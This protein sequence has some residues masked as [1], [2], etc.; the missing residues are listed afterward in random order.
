VLRQAQLVVGAQVQDRIA[1]GDSHGGPLRGDDHAFEL[2]GAGGADVVELVCCVLLEC[3]EDGGPLL[4]TIG[5]IE[6]TRF[7]GIPLAALDAAVARP[8]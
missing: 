7:A 4:P 2:V 3:T 1:I 6:R 5:S 8:L